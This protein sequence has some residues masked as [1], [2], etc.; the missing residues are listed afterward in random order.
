MPTITWGPL[1]IEKTEVTDS[2]VTQADNQK[3]V[4]ITVFDCFPPPGSTAEHIRPSSFSPEVL[5]QYLQ[6][7]EITD[8]RA[9]HGQIGGSPD[10][11]D[12]TLG[13]IS[14]RLDFVDMSVGYEGDTYDR[15]R[16][17]TEC[18]RTTLYLRVE[19]RVYAV[20]VTAN[21]QIQVGTKT[22]PVGDEIAT[23]R[24][25]QPNR[26]RFETHHEWNERCCP[27]RPQRIPPSEETNWYEPFHSVLDDLDGYQIPNPNKYDWGWGLEPGYRYEWDWRP[28][29]RIELRYKW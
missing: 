26:Y 15:M 4:A 25:R 5:R 2:S 11:T 7:E 12:A 23:Y 22:F 8:L 20:K 21:R 28:R 9:V 14:R 10:T 19:Y 6:E 16:R 3:V 29:L 18:F 1:T 24:V 13:E 27:Q 17:F